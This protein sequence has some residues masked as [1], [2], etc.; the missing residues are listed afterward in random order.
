MNILETHFKDSEVITN[1]Q[2]KELGIK[3]E[4]T[5]ILKFYK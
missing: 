2:A 4:I 1:K 5:N 3:D